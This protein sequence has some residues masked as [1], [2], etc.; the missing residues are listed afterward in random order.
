MDPHTLRVPC[1]L[2]V[3]LST[4]A[5]SAQ[6]ASLTVGTIQRSFS[7]KHNLNKHCLITA[8]LRADRTS[9][10]RYSLKASLFEIPGRNTNRAS[11]LSAASYETCVCSAGGRGCLC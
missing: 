6:L 1:A 2:S 7:R 3:N 11:L 10:S 4:V 9:K 8:L 5:T